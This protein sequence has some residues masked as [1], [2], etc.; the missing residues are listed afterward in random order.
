MG[1]EDFVVTVKNYARFGAPG[2]IYARDVSY[3]EDGMQIDAFQVKSEYV[4]LTKLNAGEIIDDADRQIEAMD[5][6][7]DLIR[8]WDDLPDAFPYS[9]KFIVIE[10]FKIIRRELFLN[11]GLAIA[12]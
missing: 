10:G 11:F 1:E 3:S 2:E 4:R 8:S 5:G 9:E 12:S 7:R 6:T